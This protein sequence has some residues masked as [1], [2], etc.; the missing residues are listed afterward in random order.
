MAILTPGTECTDALCIAVFRK[1][2]VSFFQRKKFSIT[3]SVTGKKHV[4]VADSAKTC[5]YLLG[6]CSAQHAFS[7]LMGSGPFPQDVTGKCMLDS[8]LYM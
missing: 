3:S 4:F 7:A 8:Q 2:W 6:L 1:V 5:R